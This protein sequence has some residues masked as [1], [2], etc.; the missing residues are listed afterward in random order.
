EKNIQKNQTPFTPAVSLIYALAVQ[1]ERIQRET[2]EARW[3]RH[4]AMARRTWAW[5]DEM[6][7][8]GVDLSILA[9]EGYRSPTVTCITAPPGRT[10]PEIAAAVKARGGYT[11]ATGYGKLKE[12]TFRIGHMG[13]HTVE[14]L[15]ELL[16]VLEEVLVG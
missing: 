5:V 1:V 13:D 10:G 2:L 3:A 6:R 4:E 9:P 15:E 8:R 16:G 12:Q 7:E 11:I 14:E